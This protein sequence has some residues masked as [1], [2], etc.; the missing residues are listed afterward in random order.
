MPKLKAFKKKTSE[1]F[2]GVSNYSII[3]KKL[4]RNHFIHTSNKE[5]FFS[6][7]KARKKIYQL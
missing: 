5:Q 3:F 1:Y 4:S 6:I 7:Q 2:N